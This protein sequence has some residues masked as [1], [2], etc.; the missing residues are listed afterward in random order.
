[1]NKTSDAK[2]YHPAY[3][4]VELFAFLRNSFF[5]I[6]FLFIFN[7]GVTEGWI[8]WAKIVFVV[9]AAFTVG[10]IFLSW[11]LHTYEVDSKSITLREGVFVKKVR[12]IAFDRVQNKKTSTTFIHNWFGLTSLTLETGTSS[13]DASVRFPVLKRQE[14]DD[15]V[16][17]IE[18]GTAKV[19]LPAEQE[20]GEEA[21]GLEAQPPKTERREYFRSTQRDTLRAAFT[22]LS[23]LAIFPLLLAL[24][25]QIDDFFSLEDEAENVFLYFADH[26]WLLAPLFVVAILISS[27]IGYV[28]TTIRYGNYRIEADRDR[29]Y[30]TRGVGQVHTFTIQRNKVQAIQIEQPLLKRLWGIVEIKLISAEAM[31]VEEGPA[32]NSLYPFMKTKEAYRLLTELLPQYTVQD[33]LRRLPRNTIWLK[34]IRPYYVTAIA[35]A[36]LWFIR[37]SLLWVAGILFALSVGSRL[38]DYFFTRYALEGDSIQIRTGGFTTTTFITRRERIQ[39]IEVSQSRL[40]RAFGVGSLGFTNRAKPIHVSSIQDVPDELRHEFKHW[41]VQRRVKLE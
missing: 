14:A 26:L 24:Y 9:A 13:E 35:L 40:Q 30:I 19:A 31:S 17:A 22:S 1:M 36:A 7:Y 3:L 6:L 38:F 8:F 27:V 4:L 12:T 15:I 32:T 37:P 41:F 11:W 5:F 33:N 34:L 18:R 25:F 21:E 29:I 20:D 28:Q 39:E 16:H 10:K 2:R 23:F